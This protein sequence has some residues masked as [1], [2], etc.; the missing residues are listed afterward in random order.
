MTS[1]LSSTRAKVRFLLQQILAFT[2]ISSP[3]F[4]QELPVDF[5]TKNV[6]SG[7][8]FELPVGIA[9]APDDRIFVAEKKGKV[10]VIDNGQKISEPFIDLESEVLSKHD[11][12]LLGIAVDPNFEKNRWVYLLYVVDP[13]GGRDDDRFAFSRLTRYKARSENLNQADKNSRQVLLGKDWRDGFIACSDQHLIGSLRFAQ[14]G[15]LLMSAG[16]AAEP[17]IPDAGGTRPECFGEDRFDQAEDVG[18][19]RSQY[20]GSLAGKILRVFA[21]DTLQGTE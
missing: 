17:G 4:G 13:T 9:F 3:S 12:G 21:S 10:Y 14:D 6:A 16:E 11:Q 7:A 18:A 19:F 15:T 5:V 8:K 2:L 20:L 1:S